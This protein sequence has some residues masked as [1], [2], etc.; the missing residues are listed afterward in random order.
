M[1]GDGL[2]NSSGVCQSVAQI[3]VR[4]GKVWP[5][6]NGPLDQLHSRVRPAQVVRQ[7]A[8]PMQG[9]RMIGLPCEDLA[10]DFL[11]FGQTAS[12]VVRHAG[13]ELLLESHSAGIVS[14]N[15]PVEN[16]RVEQNSDNESN[17]DDGCQSIAQ[18]KPVGTKSNRLNLRGFLKDEP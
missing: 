8:E 10:I 13:F 3:G 4:P 2:V 9:I 11:R 7:H 6:L 1:R 16:L 17:P 12:P 14:A 5:E 18:K 15:P